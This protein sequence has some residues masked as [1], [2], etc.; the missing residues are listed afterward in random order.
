MAE[1][2]LFYTMTMAKLYADQGHLAKAGKIYKYLLK[3]EPGRQD[4]IDALAEIGKK[5]ADLD[6][7]LSVLFSKWFDLIFTYNKL[8]KLKTL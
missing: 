2:T 8:I 3:Q 7:N 6:E 5:N 1:E 4:I